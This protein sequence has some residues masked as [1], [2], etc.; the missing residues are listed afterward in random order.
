MK[1]TRTFTLESGV[2]TRFV[3]DLNK[4]FFFLCMYDSVLSP[5][6]RLTSLGTTAAPSNDFFVGACCLATKGFGRLFLEDCASEM[7]SLM[8]S[9]FTFDL[10]VR[11]T[12]FLIEKE[13]ILLHQ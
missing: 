2:F 4:T 11:R 10:L 8:L 3:F 13:A 6:I 1:L 9:L 5:R 7:A 12:G